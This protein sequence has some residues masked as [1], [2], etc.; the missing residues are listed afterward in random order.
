MVAPKLV[1][2]SSATAAARAEGDA[3]P[4][5]LATL[6]TPVGVAALTAGR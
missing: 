1:S 6:A 2:P 4:A 3:I 5:G